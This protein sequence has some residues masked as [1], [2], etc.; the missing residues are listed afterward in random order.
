VAC[1]CTD[2]ARHTDA[3]RG[4][5]GLGLVEVVMAVVVLVIVSVAA[6]NVVTSSSKSELTTREGDQGLLVASAAMENA[7][8][9]DCGITT[10]PLAPALLDVRRERCR[11]LGDASWTEVNGPLTFVVNL[12]TTWVAFRANDTVTA[13]GVA[14][15]RLRRTV[16][17]TW[18]RGGRVRS[19]TLTAMA[20]VPPDAIAFSNVGSVT[21]RAPGGTAALELAPGYVVTHTADA[22]GK[23]RFPFLEYGQYGVF[24]NGVESAQS[25]Q[26]TPTVPDAD[27]E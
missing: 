1:R 26:I 6:L 8:A 4:D 11:E 24:V 9:Y 22:D 3:G 7:A 19:R 27:V 5:D 17:V 10:S 16:T 23:V 2:R 13:P 20:A 15:L 18:T 12:T 25:V 14:D 21:V